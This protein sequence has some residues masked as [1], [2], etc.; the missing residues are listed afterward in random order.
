MNAADTVNAAVNVVVTFSGKSNGNDANNQFT[1]ADQSGGHVITALSRASASPVKKTQIDI[2]GLN[3]GTDASQL[4]VFL[5]ETL[6]DGTFNIKY[7]L[8]ILTVTNN[9]V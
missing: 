8:G 6:A 7:E 9:L 4:R 2:S 1:F 5:L 3:F